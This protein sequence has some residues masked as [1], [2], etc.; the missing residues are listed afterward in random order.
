M[1]FLHLDMECY[2]VSGPKNFIAF[3]HVLRHFEQ[4]E[5]KKKFWK[6]LLSGS[7]E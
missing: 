6:I 1:T 3:F 4:F 5:P 2:L 7:D